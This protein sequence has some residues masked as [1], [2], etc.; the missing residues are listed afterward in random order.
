MNKSR[1]KISVSGELLLQAL[2]FPEDTELVTVLEDREGFLAGRPVVELYLYHPDLPEVK[3]G[4]FIPE[5]SPTWVSTYYYV[6]E[7]WNLDNG[8]GAT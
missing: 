1:V 2:R 6:F 8:R 7:D 4:R 5:C 3:E